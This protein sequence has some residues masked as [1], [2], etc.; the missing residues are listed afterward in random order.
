MNL[1]YEHMLL[2]SEFLAKPEGICDDH[3][4]SLSPGPNHAKALDD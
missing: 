1:L 2:S 4:T 3:C